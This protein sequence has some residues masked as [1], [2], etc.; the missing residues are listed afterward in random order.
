MVNQNTEKSDSLLLNAICT[1]LF[2]SIIST[3][4]SIMFVLIYSDNYKAIWIVIVLSTTYFLKS[5]HTAE[6]IFLS[7]S[8]SKY[9]SKAKVLG[10]ISSFSIKLLLVRYDFSLIYF[11]IAIAIE[12]FITT[13]GIIYFYKKTYKSKLIANFNF[14]TVKKI[15]SESWPI[16]FSTAAGIMYTQIDKLMLGDLRGMSDVGIYVIYLQLLIVPRFFVSSLNNSYSPYLIKLYKIDIENFEKNAI[17]IL[18]LNTWVLIWYAAIILFF[19]NGII[20]LFFGHQYL[21]SQFLLLL[22]CL[23]LLF[24]V[25][26]SLRVDYS[27]LVG[28]NKILLGVRLLSLLV[29]LILNYY[30]IPIM[31]IEGAALASLVMIV[32]N[33][34]LA[35]LFFQKTKLYARIYAKSLLLALLQKPL[36]EILAQLNNKRKN[37]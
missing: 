2:G 1:K 30:F 26:S 5:L 3:I 28:A 33:D 25:P 15:L 11:A 18:S 21:A 7:D 8:K 22:L 24:W 19:G 16:A 31:G 6:I 13:C 37:L 32:I 9:V 10:V 34:F 17:K 36:F 4:I 29:N 12:S 35:N 14:T 20:K 23:Q 27:I